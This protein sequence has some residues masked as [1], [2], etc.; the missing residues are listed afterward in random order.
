MVGKQSSAAA[1][2]STDNFPAKVNVRISQCYTSS[3][4]AINSM[5][6]SSTN[7]IDRF[8]KQGALCK[9]Q[10]SKVRN[11]RFKVSFDGESTAV[12]TAMLLEH[13]FHIKKEVIQSQR[14]SLIL[15]E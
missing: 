6:A 8:F 2:L 9:P 13:D 5:S 11:G 4:V 3:D 12:T 7:T 1:D 14:R 15:V 10:L